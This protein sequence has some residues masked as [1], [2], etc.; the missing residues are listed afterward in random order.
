MNQYQELLHAAAEFADGDVTAT[1]AAGGGGGGIPTSETKA[2]DGG[3]G[4]H[5]TQK[6]S[7]I[8]IGGLA[9]LFLEIAFLLALKSAFKK[10]KEKHFYS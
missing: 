4:R 9:R 3:G 7:A 8:I 1:R 2:G 5:N 10:K 6:T